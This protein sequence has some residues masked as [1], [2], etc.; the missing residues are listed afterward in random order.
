[1]LRA[2]F[3]MFEICELHDHC[4][5]PY[6]SAVLKPH[7]MSTSLPVLVTAVNADELT[8]RLRDAALTERLRVAIYALRD[9][10]LLPEWQPPDAPNTQ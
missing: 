2:Q 1:M 10:G 8:D 5:R 6:L 9:R 7:Y 3:A 4:G